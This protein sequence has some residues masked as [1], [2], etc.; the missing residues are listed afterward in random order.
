MV[1][2]NPTQRLKMRQ[3]RIGFGQ[4]RNRNS[5]QAQSLPETQRVARDVVYHRHFLSVLRVFRD[6]LS[7][8]S[9]TF[10]LKSLWLPIFEVVFGFLGFCR[11]G[12][13]RCPYP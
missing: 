10:P 8:K 4:Q 6:S 2:I 1:V 9:S 12:I 5:L 7:L 3:L 11:G 13:M